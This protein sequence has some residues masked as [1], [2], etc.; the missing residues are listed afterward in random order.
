MAKKMFSYRNVIF[1][2][3]G[4]PINTVKVVIEFHKEHSSEVEHLIWSPKSR[5]LNIVK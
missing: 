5:D 3:N 1:E 4:D 2:V